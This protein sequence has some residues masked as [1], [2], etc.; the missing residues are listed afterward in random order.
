MGHA[1]QEACRC[2]RKSKKLWPSAGATTKKHKNSSSPVL[3]QKTFCSPA[4]RLSFVT[5]RNCK[6]P[7]PKRFSWPKPRTERLAPRAVTEPRCVAAITEVEPSDPHRLIPAPHTSQMFRWMRKRAKSPSTR[8]GAPT[9]VA[10][11]NPVLVEGQIEG[12]TYMGAAEVALEEMHYGPNPVRQGMLVGP[13]ARLPH[14]ND[15]RHPQLK[16]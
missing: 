5:T 12:S 7:W 2:A 4:A 1:A 8:F 11:L 6:C 9:T 15:A 16:R 13:P 14:P 10:K 3:S